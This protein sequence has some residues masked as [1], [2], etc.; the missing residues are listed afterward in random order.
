M[1]CPNCKAEYQ[2]GFYICADCNIDLVDVLPP[3]PEI[4][5]VK[6]EEVMGTYNQADIAMI[7]SL[8]DSENI[9]YY[10]NA[11]HFMTVRPLSEPARLMVKHDEVEIAKDLLKGLRFGIT[12]IDL[13]DDSDE[14]ENE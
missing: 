6:Y 14:I 9:T 7:K 5:F 2:E 1:F 11:E 10:F 3:E 8:L 4:E 13:G 12:G